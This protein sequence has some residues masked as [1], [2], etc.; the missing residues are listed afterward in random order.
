M[1]EAWSE[2]MEVQMLVTPSS[3]PPPNPFFLRLKRAT[4]PRFAELPEWCHCEAMPSCPPSPPGPAGE[5]GI[6]G[7]IQSMVKPPL[8]NRK[9]KK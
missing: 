2:L 3:Q 6:D 5:P 7:G 9:I 4:D 8:Y 1:D